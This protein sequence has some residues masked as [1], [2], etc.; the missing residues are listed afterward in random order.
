[1]ENMISIKW[2]GVGAVFY[3]YGA[4]LKSEIIQTAHQQRLHFNNWDVSLR[5][6]TDPYLILYFVVPIA[7]LFFIKSIVIDFDYQIL[8]RLGSFKK[9]IYY[10]FKNF[11]R[12][13]FPLLFLW[14]FMSLFMAIG[15]PHSWEWSEVSKIASSTN[16]LD[17][18]VYFFHKPIFAFIAQLLL[19]LFTFSLLHIAFAIIY[20]LTKKKNLILFL[21]VFFFLYSG[22]GFKLLPTK[23]AFLS[24]VCFLSITN[25][26]RAFHSPLPIFSIVIIFLVVCIWFLKF[27][28][29]NK[30]YTFIL[31]NHLCPLLLIF[32]FVS[33][34][35]EQQLDH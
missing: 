13:A 1:M 32:L 14:G 6:L 10:S 4:M 27:L 23:F 35:S 24:P 25:G 19:L 7:L 31:S 29:L 22:I 5:L 34:G 11:W 20:V 9:W 8:I 33:W 17:K 2:I 15:F 21:S 26:V 16:T 30:K 28:D 18:L 3:F 12:M